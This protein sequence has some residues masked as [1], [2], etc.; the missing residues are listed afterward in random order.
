[1]SSSSHKTRKRKEHLFFLF[2]PPTT[3][4]GITGYRKLAVAATLTIATSSQVRVPT[5][6]HHSHPLCYA[7]IG[8]IRCTRACR[9]LFAKVNEFGAGVK[10]EKKRKKRG[11]K[12]ERD[13]TRP[14]FGFFHAGL[15]PPMGPRF[16]V[17]C[18]LLCRG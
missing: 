15:P 13:F 12:E 17:P 10:K 1:M 4:M 2:F 14:V 16:P 11:V 6:R 18:V 3:N 7:R 9:P 5:Q 8:I